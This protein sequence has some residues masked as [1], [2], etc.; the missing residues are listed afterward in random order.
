MHLPT[1]P[2]STVC[3]TR[4]GQEEYLCAEISQSIALGYRHASIQCTQVAPQ[5]IVLVHSSHEDL[6]SLPLFFSAQALPNA[7]AVQADSISSWTNAILE[8]LIDTFGNEPPP[9]GL[10][11]FDRSSIETGKQ[12]GR[13]QRIEESLL[14]L[15]KQRRRSYLRTLNKPL[16]QPTSLVQVVL[17]EPTEGYISIADK[18]LRATYKASVSPNLAGYHEVEDDKRPPSRAFKKLREAIEVFSL[19]LRRGEKAVDLGAS[20]GGWTYVLRQHG[21]SVTAIDRSPLAE[22]FTRDRGVSWSA[23]NA[24]KWTPRT[25]VDWLV[26]DVITTPENTSSLLRNWITK[27]LCNHFC[28]TVKFKGAPAIEPLVSLAAFLRSNVSY[29][30]GRQLTHNKNELTLV[31]SR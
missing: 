27:G 25:P 31:G 8:S 11:I 4:S 23:G 22:S 29:F 30:D 6:C 19:T 14:G 7:R 3:I 21:L 9:W 2:L 24:L 15:L 28:V 18:T 26:C 1:E 17:V 5:T 16:S 20:P 12:Y 13:A 10:H